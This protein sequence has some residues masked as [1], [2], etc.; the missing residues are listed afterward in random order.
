MGK[1]TEI[2]TFY[3]SEITLMD[4]SVNIMEDVKVTTKP[5]TRAMWLLE[6]VFTFCLRRTGRRMVDLQDCK[7][8]EAIYYEHDNNDQQSSS[9][10]DTKRDHLKNTRTSKTN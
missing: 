1:T 4:M 6:T 8:H 9:F 2:Q 3:E 5:F 10:L 7:E